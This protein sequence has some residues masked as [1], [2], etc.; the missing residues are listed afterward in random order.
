MWC[1][2]VCRV[3]NV[4]ESLWRVGQSIDDH[5]DRMIECLCALL[6]P[7]QK[8]RTAR[9]HSL[10]NQQPRRGIKAAHVV[11][12]PAEHANGE[13][14]LAR[15]AVRT[16]ATAARRAGRGD[17]V[18]AMSGSWRGAEPCKSRCLSCSGDLERCL[19]IF[20]CCLFIQTFSSCF[21]FIGSQVNRHRR[22]G[23]KYQVLQKRN[24]WSTSRPP[25][26]RFVSVLMM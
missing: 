23:L 18:G 15:L 3:G 13:H 21:R 11:L 24:H 9:G 12:G 6:C 5:I 8:Y 16:V 4:V 10:F 14:S 7:A 19:F 17:M 20:W 1:E 26:R 22:S 2:R 25:Y